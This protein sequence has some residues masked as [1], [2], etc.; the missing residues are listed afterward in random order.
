MFDTF[1]LL[2]QLTERDHDDVE[3]LSILGLKLMEEA[4]ETAQ[5]ILAVQDRCR[6]KPGVCGLSGEAV[7]TLIC[8]LAIYY[9]E[10]RSFIGL[11]DAIREKLY[12]WLGEAP[13]DT[14]DAMARYYVV[15]VGDMDSTTV[16]VIKS[17]TW[18]AANKHADIW[19]DGSDSPNSEVRLVGPT[20]LGYNRLLQRT[21]KSGMEIIDLTKG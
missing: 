6:K 5:E 17:F 13:P 12:K 7:D 1:E 19:R 14:G 4:G 21:L 3:G 8:A 10:K 20:D 9:H 18:E 15:R 2:G 16:G 11:D